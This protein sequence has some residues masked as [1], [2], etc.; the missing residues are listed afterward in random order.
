MEIRA[1]VARAPHAPLS[2]EPVELSGPGPDEVLVELVSTGICHTDIAIVEQLVPLPLPM[3]LGHEGAGRV[4]EVGAEVTNL[5][6]GDP[7]VLGFANCGACANCLAHH[8]AYCD[9]FPV[10]NMAGRRPD[11]SATLHDASG[12]EL[13][14]SYFGQSSFATHAVT[15]ARNA[16]KVR[17]DAPLGLLGPLGCGLMT[18]AGTVLNSLRPLSG[19]SFGIFGAGALGFAAMFAARIAGCTTIVAIDRV[20]SR[21]ELARELG[22]DEV[23]DTSEEDLGS[24]LA[25]MGGL[26]YAIDT[27]GVPAVIEAMVASIR[28]RGACALVGASHESALGFDV[29]ALLGGKTIMGVIEGD[30]EPQTFIPQLV[31]HHLAGR[32]PIDRIARFYDFDDANTAIADAVSGRTIKPILRF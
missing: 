27:S 14:G 22:A 29:M 6:V 4:A 24:R 30:A 2:V 1:A 26:D 17:A 9:A 21:L 8:P 3:V 20:A 31:D 32:F 28:A 11:G 15:T 19:S 10:L 16:V 5:S 23:I 13:S 18:G 7:V 25:A 12:V